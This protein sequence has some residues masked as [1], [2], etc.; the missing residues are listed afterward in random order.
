MIPV[1]ILS[2]HLGK[3][4]QVYTVKDSFVGTLETK[5]FGLLL[6]LT[7]TDQYSLDRYG[8]TYVATDAVIAIRERK[9]HAEKN[10]KWEDDTCDSNKEGPFPDDPKSANAYFKGDEPKG[11]FRSGTGV[12]EPKEDE[13]DGE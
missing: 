10:E 13:K 9:P 8:P 6:M 4:V 2:E 7:P 3:V 5:N 1:A 11:Y 12:N